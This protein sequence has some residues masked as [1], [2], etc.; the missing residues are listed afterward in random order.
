MLGRQSRLVVTFLQQSLPNSKL[1]Y[2]PRAV[3]APPS[4]AAGCTSETPVRGAAAV[5]GGWRRHL[6]DGAFP[7][8]L[9]RAN[10]VLRFN[11]ELTAF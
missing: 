2:V 8:P 6:T 11:V 9:P 5:S 10:I 3:A 7:Q 1:C 4:F